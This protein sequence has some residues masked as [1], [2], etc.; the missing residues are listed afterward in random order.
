MLYS[1]IIFNSITLIIERILVKR[2]SSHER[3]KNIA[4]S[5]PSSHF[6]FPP[7]RKNIFA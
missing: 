4:S 1:E 6:V 3:A 7:A 2:N 5:N